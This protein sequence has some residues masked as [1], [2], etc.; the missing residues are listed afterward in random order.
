MQL[1]LLQETEVIV[2]SI[3]S[4][5]WQTFSWIVIDVSVLLFLQR[6]IIA[7]HAELSAVDTTVYIGASPA[8]CL[9]SQND[10]GLHGRNGKGFP[11]AKT[12]KRSVNENWRFSAFKSP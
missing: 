5:V 4:A 2:S 3:R 11:R 12:L 6:V 1:G 8:I 9:L 7:R 10:R